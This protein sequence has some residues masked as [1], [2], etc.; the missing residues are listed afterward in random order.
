[1]RLTRLAAAL[2]FA[3]PLAPAATRAQTQTFESFPV[4]STLP[5]TL[6]VGGLTAGR[7][8]TVTVLSGTP[9]VELAPSLGGVVGRAL[10]LDP[11]EGVLF[12]FADLIDRID[13]D[14]AG[15]AGAQV[16]VTGIAPVTVFIPLP[17]SGAEQ[18]AF[19]L[20]PA[21]IFTHEIGVV[22]TNATLYVD[23]IGAVPE[24]ATLALV[25]GG[26]LALGVVGRRRRVATE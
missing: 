1:M 24:P 13:F 23:N 25:A 22:A 26:L 3:A 16:G 9:T 11:G 6:L 19:Y 14:V 10:R 12:T 8:A 5:A 4:G 20:P 2:L 21:G 15:S 17:P 18:I 7:T